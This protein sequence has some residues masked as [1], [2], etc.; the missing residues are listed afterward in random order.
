[1]AYS[2]M[3][4]SRRLK[5]ETRRCENQCEA[6]SKMQKNIQYRVRSVVIADREKTI[7]GCVV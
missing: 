3:Q 2:K 1:M 7:I 5:R 6:V 4:K